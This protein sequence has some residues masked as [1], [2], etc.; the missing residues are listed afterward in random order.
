MDDKK[1][2]RQLEKKDETALI[3]LIER[4]SAYVSTIVRNIVNGALYS[5][6]IEEITADVFI[7]L[8]NC[9]GKLRVENLRSYIAAIARNLAIDRLRVMHYTVNLDEIEFGD[10]S[11]I[12]FETEHSMLAYELKRTINEMDSRNRE[13]LLRFYYYYQQIPQIAAE[14]SMSEV[15]CKT[16]LHRAR[17]KLKQKLIERGYDN[18]T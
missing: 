18:E 5:S 1:L 4:Y 3:A 9:S 2:V 8:W 16:A 10:G 17:Y 14:M 13:L 7:R 6:D 11:D 12:E 15:A